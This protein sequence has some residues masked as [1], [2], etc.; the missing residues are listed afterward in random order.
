M[1]RCWEKQTRSLLMN[2]HEPQLITDIPIVR[3]TPLELHAQ[4]EVKRSLTEEIVDYLR[5]LYQEDPTAIKALYA[6]RVNCSEQLEQHRYCMCCDGTVGALGVLKGFLEQKGMPKI[7]A[8]LDA[9]TREL[10]DFT[11][12]QNCPDCD[13]VIGEAHRERC[14][15]E[16]CSVCSGQRLGC[17]CAGH[18]PNETKWTGRWPV[19]R[20]DQEK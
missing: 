1:Q 17:D 6:V 15:V 16:R 10:M 13:A 9:W 2:K 12:D 14:D 8:N 7:T 19:V 3:A 5:E 20:A 18:N 11:A 4:I